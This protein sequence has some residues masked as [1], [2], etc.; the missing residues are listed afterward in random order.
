MNASVAAT[1]LTAVSQPLF[2][3]NPNQYLVLGAIVM[4]TFIYLL[5]CKINTQADEFENTFQQ[6][7]RANQ[8]LREDLSE[9]QTCYMRLDHQIANVVICN[10]SSLDCNISNTNERVDKLQKKMAELVGD[11]NFMDD[12]F[13]EVTDD[14]CDE[15]RNIKSQL[16]VLAEK[17]ELLSTDVSTVQQTVGTMRDKINDL[18]GDIGHMDEQFDAVTGGLSDGFRKL[19]AKLMALDVDITKSGEA[20]PAAELANRQLNEFLETR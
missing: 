20:K 17:H 13:E 14:M 10:L 2:P 4:F 5:E 18:D 6:L 16:Y 19:T 9:I 12:H 1:N 15:M 7:V 3:S 8:V 11:I